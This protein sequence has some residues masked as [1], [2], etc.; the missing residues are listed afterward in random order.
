M[1]Q[2]TRGIKCDIFYA[3]FIFELRAN[4]EKN[5]TKPRESHEKAAK[6]RRENEQ[7]MNKGKRTK[8][9]LYCYNVRGKI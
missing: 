9:L 7:R 1:R 6:K 4:S 2:K 5:L 8:I 3:F